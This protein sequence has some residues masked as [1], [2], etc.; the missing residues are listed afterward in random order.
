LKPGGIL[1]V[2]IPNRDSAWGFLSRITPF[3][4]HIF[5]KK[6]VEGDE[7]AGKPGHPPFPTFYD[8]VV[9]RSGIHKFCEKHGLVIKAE[10]SAGHGRRDRQIFGFLSGLLV[11]IVYLASV[12]RLSLQYASL[13]YVIEKPYCHLCVG[14]MPVDCEGSTGSDSPEP[15]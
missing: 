10:Y 15:V 14:P 3:W 11:R 5:Y 7:N 13:I 1:I 6:Y 9:S 2:T 4:L 12:R 8:K